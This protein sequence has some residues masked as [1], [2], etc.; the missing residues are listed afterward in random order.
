MR[1]GRVRDTGHELDQC[2]CRTCGSQVH[3]FAELND[4][5]HSCKRCHLKV[6]H[7]IEYFSEVREVPGMWTSD[8]PY[9]VQDV[10]GHKC[11]KCNY[12]EIEYT[13]QPR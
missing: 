11:T 4:E 9:F 3:D 7:E 8:I 13:G 5:L 2:T 6:E 12:E 10:S 1:C